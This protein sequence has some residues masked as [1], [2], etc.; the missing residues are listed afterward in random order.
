V[1][2][3]V[4]VNWNSGPLLAACLDSIQ[5]S[6]DARLVRGIF[7]VDNNSRD[8]SWDVSCSGPVPVHLLCNSTNRGFA[9]ACNQGANAGE[10]EFVLFLNPDSELLPGSLSTPLETLQ[11]PDAEGIGVCGIQLLDERGKVARSC[12]RLPTWRSMA[13]MALRLS[14]VSKRW[15]PPHFLKEWDHAETRVVD[16]VI[17]AFFLVRRSQFDALG[18]FDERFFVYFEEVD[19]CLRMRQHGFKTLYLATAQAIHAGAG[20]SSQV[21]ARAL[22][23]SLRSRLQ[24]ARKHF[25]GPQAALVCL[26]TLVA[27][28]LIRLVTVLAGLKL[29]SAGQLLYGFGMLWRS[30]FERPACPSNTVT[31]HVRNAS[32]PI[33]KAG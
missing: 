29:R 28:P 2:D 23:Y 5:A 18:G 33:R 30:Q 25:T 1:L 15:F 19:L 26:L 17:G 31:V 22:F 27:E 13:A 8:G 9:A 10:A 24:F 21:R 12:S 11:S 3:I 6:P 7:V 4:I 20:C 16:Q 14:G 32:A